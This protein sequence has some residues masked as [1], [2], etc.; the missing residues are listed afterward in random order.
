M[1]VVLIH[2]VLFLLFCYLRMVSVRI[3]SLKL[4]VCVWVLCL[5]ATFSTPVLVRG[6]AGLVGLQPI[7]RRVVVRGMPAGDG[8]K[9][10]CVQ[11]VCHA[12]GRA[13][14]SVCFSDHSRSHATISGPCRDPEPDVL[15]PVLLH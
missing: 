8:S 2:N 5:C 1:A 6:A 13:S 15:L 10:V 14:G 4:Y 9:G 3:V 11:C 12:R 7:W